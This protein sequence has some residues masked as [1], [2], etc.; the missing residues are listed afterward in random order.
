MVI[1]HG[2]AHPILKFKKN[3][4]QKHVVRIIFY[5]EKE[6]H[7]RSKINSCVKVVLS[8]SKKFLF[9]C[10]NESPLKTMKMLFISF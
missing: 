3:L 2:P 7:A 6:A 1:F 4:L 10:L 5:E 8:P 9:I